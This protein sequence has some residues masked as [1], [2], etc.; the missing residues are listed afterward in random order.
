MTSSEHIVVVGGGVIGAGI[1]FELAKRGVRV[2]LIERGRI[3]GE[4]SWASAGIDLAPQPAVGQTGA[5]RAGPHQPGA[6]SGAR[7]TSW[8][9]ETGIGIDYRRPGEWVIAVDEEHAEA[10]RRWRPGR[11][12]MGLDVEHVPPGVRRGD[13]AGAA[14]IPGRGLVSSRR[15]VALGLPADPGAGRRGA[16]ARR[17]GARGDAGRRAAP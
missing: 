8:R 11:R 3:G 13:G 1:A 2:T 9:S 15:R 4:A 5:G 14:G 7:S 6:L 10:E 17:D 12:G 16:T